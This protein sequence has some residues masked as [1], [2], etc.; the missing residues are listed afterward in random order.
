MSAYLETEGGA[1]KKI[2]KDGALGLGV[3]LYK[4]GKFSEAVS[5]F[6]KYLE[7]EQS[8]EDRKVCLYNR[9]MAHCKLGLYR[10][11]LQDGEQCIRMDRYWAMGYK[12]KGMALE[13]MK[14]PTVAVSTYLYGQKH[15][16]NM[17][18]KTDLVLGPL[19]KRLNREI[20]FL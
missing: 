5:Q 3:D 6:G 16:T 17:D 1:R 11:A 14:R 18:P 15:C 20:G 12:C 7:E 2:R 10:M 19:I 8:I 9:G 13:G 4:E